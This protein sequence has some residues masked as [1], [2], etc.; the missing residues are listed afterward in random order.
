ML[1]ALPAPCA[2]SIGPVL[3]DQRRRRDETIRW[4][5][6]R[7][8]E[9][10]TWAFLDSS[11][12][13]PAVSGHRAPRR[14]APR[15]SRVVR[16]GR[17]H[18]GVHHRREHRER[19]VAAQ[20]APPGLVR[21]RRSTSVLLRHR[22]AEGGSRDLRGPGRGPT[23]GDDPW[24]PLHGCRAGRSNSGG[25][26]ASPVSCS[27][28]PAR[29]RITAFR[30]PRRLTVTP[31]EPSPA[32]ETGTF[33]RRRF[34]LLSSSCYRSPATSG[35]RFLFGGRTMAHVQLEDTAQRLVP[36]TGTSLSRGAGSGAPSNPSPPPPI[37]PACS[38]PWERS[39][40]RP[41]A[42]GSAWTST[43]D[44]SPSR[45]RAWPSGAR[46]APTTGTTRGC[47]RGSTRPRSEPPGGGARATSTTS[48]AA[49]C[50]KFAELETA[51]PARVP[52]EL[53]DRLHGYFSEAEIVELTAWV[54]LENFRSRL[55][56]RPRPAQ[57][58]ILRHLRHPAGRRGGRRQR[59]AG[60]GP[61]HVEAAVTGASARQP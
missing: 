28:A 56:C 53:M 16:R 6:H 38:W 9:Q 13:R 11:P 39:R 45:P 58:G 48:A 35:S 47:T 18:P 40:P 34:P 7:M 55:Q 36:S 15:R 49:P 51:T 31:R 26:T 54:A 17:P 61:A 32:L 1:A 24:R 14:T 60:T 46:G 5:T 19:P 4:G 41:S 59:V 8:T 37:T 52:D 2:R 23:V 44:G 33:R 42:V 43:S 50:S 27:F 29:T 30:A 25:A 22:R 3:R 20:R 10:E 21:R 12:P 57:P